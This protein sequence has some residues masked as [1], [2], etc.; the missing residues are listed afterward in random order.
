M[1]GAEM[2][3]LRSCDYR[4]RHVN[5]IKLPSDSCPVR[6]YEIDELGK[7]ENASG[8]IADV[9][10]LL[11]E[12]LADW[13]AFLEQ[14]GFAVGGAEFVIPGNLAG[15]GYGAIDRHTGCCHMSKNQA[16]KW[17]PR[18]MTPAVRAAARRDAA[19]RAPTNATPY[20]LRRG[21]I[22]A[23]L[24]GESAQSVAEQCGTSLEMLSR[25]YS[26]EIDGFGKGRPETLDA[27][28]QRA[29]AMACVGSGDRSL[30]LVA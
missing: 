26:Y 7:T 29:R 11:S 18:C 22:Y 15:P 12:D 24:R 27:Q 16:Q 10:G 6:V 28:W 21:G 17:Q 4:Q 8:R 20:S 23:R 9:P 2:K 13:R 19:R 30:Q 25:H 1:W 3:A 5:A 14:E